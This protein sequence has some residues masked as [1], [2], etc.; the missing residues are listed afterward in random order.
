MYV[1]I[2][3]IRW[4]F[5]AFITCPS[6]L[7]AGPALFDRWLQLVPATD[8]SFSWSYPSN[9]DWGAE[10]PVGLA[11]FDFLVFLWWV[12]SGGSGGAGGGMG[13]VV[14]L[15]ITEESGLL[16]GIFV[17][18]DWSKQ[19]FSLEAE[20]TSV[21]LLFAANLLE[22]L[23]GFPL[24]SGQ[25][26]A[27]GKKK[28][29]IWREDIGRLL[30]AENAIFSILKSKKKTEFHANFVFY[31]FC[32]LSAGVFFL[33]F[34]FGF[35]SSCLLRLVFIVVLCPNVSILLICLFVFTNSNFFDFSFL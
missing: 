16:S 3:F 19:W 15:E 20:S 29:R 27:Q 18:S 22:C 5:T 35:V 8:S 34:W 11:V 23:V 2:S 6:D 31:S 14:E 33:C 7:S 26:W 13:W 12:R 21:S 1:F 32:C 28:K 4:C 25:G 17:A 30:P 9:V 10:E 24:S